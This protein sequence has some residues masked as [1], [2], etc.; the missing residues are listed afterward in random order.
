MEPQQTHCDIHWDSPPMYTQTFPP[1]PLA[2][3]LIP[4]NHLMY[5]FSICHYQSTILRSIVKCYHM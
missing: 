2:T 3:L 4:I 1:H 5:V